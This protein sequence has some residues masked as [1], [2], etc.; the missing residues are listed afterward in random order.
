MCSWACSTAFVLRMHLPDP[1]NLLLLAYLFVLLPLGVYKSA[2]RFEAMR[3]NRS[4][5]KAA[6]RSTAGTVPTPTSI[7]IGT[8]FNMGILGALAFMAADEARLRL[9]RVDHFGTREFVA[10]VVWLVASFSVGL[11]SRAWRSEAELRDMPMLDLVPRTRRDWLT[12]GAVAVVAGVCEEAA[13]RG[14]GFNALHWWIS[15]FPL[16]GAARVATPV[17]ALLVAG[18]FALA[19][20]VQGSK[21]VAIIF[22]KALLMQVLVWY[23]GTLVGA[24][25][26]H[27]VLDGL[28]AYRSLGLAQRLEANASAS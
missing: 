17:A 28:T 2:R 6:G 22:V 13:Y 10:C 27:V 14:M 15:G 23:T 11:L 7:Y 26:G 25:V 24:M 9:F 21:S 4:A 1:F 20:Q 3:A 19:H 18:A 16:D 8:L 12:F 5:A